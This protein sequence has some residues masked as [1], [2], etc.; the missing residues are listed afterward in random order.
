VEYIPRLPDSIRALSLTRLNGYRPKSQGFYQSVDQFVD[1]KF[2]ANVSHLERLYWETQNILYDGDKQIN[3]APGAFDLMSNLKE[4]ILD[5]NS[6]SEESSLHNMLATKSLTYASISVFNVLHLSMLPFP[7]ESISE[8]VSYN[9]VVLGVHSSSTRQIDSNFDLCVFRNFKKLQVLDLS[10]SDITS[11]FMK[12]KLP[13]LRELILAYNNMQHFPEFCSYTESMLPNLEFL[14]VS[15]NYIRT[16]EVAQTDPTCTIALK[17]LNVSANPLRPDEMSWAFFKFS[18]LRKNVAARV[19]SSWN[20]VEICQSADIVS[21][22]MEENFISFDRDKS[23]PT[24]FGACHNLSH[25]YLDNN[26]MSLVTDDRFQIMFG[27]LPLLAFSLQATLFSEVTTKTFSSLTRLQYLDLSNN[28]I[29]YI[30]NGA[31]D[32]LVDLRELYLSQNMIQTIG[33][34]TFSEKLKVPLKVLRLG[35]NPFVCSCDL[36]WFCGWMKAYPEYFFGQEIRITCSEKAKEKELTNEEITY[37]CSNSAENVEKFAMAPQ[38]YLLTHEISGYIIATFSS[39]ILS[40]TA[41]LL[42]YS[43]RWD[44]RLLLYEAFRGRDDGARQRRFRENNFRFDVFVSYAKEDHRWVRGQLMAELEGR[45]G[46]RLCIHE[47]DFIPGNNVVDNIAECVESSKK[48]IMVFSKDFVLSQWCQFELTYC[49]RHVMDYDDAL[50]V[51]CVDDVASREMTT[52]MMAV[53]KTTTYIQWAKHPDAIRA[54]LGRV[55]QSLE[56]IMVREH[57]V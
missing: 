50:I 15:S 2:F 7:R 16:F 57:R 1:S 30:P 5:T 35:S 51:V 11:L 31:F 29:N 32:K 9:E 47:R 39:L 21:L 8:D 42:F 4:L 28:K 45:L 48:M 14:D 55:R 3:V 27:H 40:L 13:F 46:L 24:P 49:L 41:G 52:A 26:D 34:R 56:E 17:F 54:F 12:C 36:L 6:F 33:E 37:T 53:M 10:Y 19:I 44:L 18:S 38:A 20:K 25:L 43:Y 22:H 23:S